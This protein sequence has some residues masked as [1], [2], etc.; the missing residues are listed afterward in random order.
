MKIEMNRIT[1]GE[2]DLHD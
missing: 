1:K 2:D